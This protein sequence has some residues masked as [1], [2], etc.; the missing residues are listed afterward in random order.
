MGTLKTNALGGGGRILDL[1]TELGLTK[2]NAFNLNLSSKTLAKK[3][4]IVG[5]L[6]FKV[7]RV[8]LPGN[9][10][11]TK[12]FFDTGSMVCTGY[13][14]ALTWGDYFRIDKSNYTG[15]QA[16]TTAT[17]LKP[18]RLYSTGY[19]NTQFTS[20]YSIYIYKNLNQWSNMSGSTQTPEG[21]PTGS[22]AEIDIGDIMDIRVS[23]GSSTAVD[24]SPNITQ[25]YIVRDQTLLFKDI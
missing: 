11:P 12:A 7:V 19:E 1:E 18:C 3:T 22:F 13:I 6:A 15:T 16:V 10:G 25:N 14:E 21:W 23:N 8:K 17:C 4:G 5:S 24:K 9:T 2:L 20:G